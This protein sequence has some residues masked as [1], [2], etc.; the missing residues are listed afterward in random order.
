[1]T[2]GVMPNNVF[3]SSQQ[4]EWLLGG[5]LLAAGCFCISVSLV[6]QVRLH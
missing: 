2:S 4:S 1:M 3:F 5:F 6:M